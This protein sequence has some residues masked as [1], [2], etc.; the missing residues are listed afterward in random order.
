MTK[1]SWDPTAYAAYSS[2]TVGKSTAHIYTKSG[3][4]PKLDP[5]G[6]KIRES[7]D[8]ATYPASTALIVGLDV[9]GS[10]GMI[11]DTL[12]RQGLGVL[13]QE[14]L[15]RKPITDPQIMFMA[16]GDADYDRGPLQVSQ[17]EVDNCIIEQLTSIWLE[18]G[19]GGN[20]HESYNMPWYFAA[21][22][23]SIDCFE[24]RKKKGYLFTVGDEPCPDILT[25]QHVE[26]FLGEHMERDLETDELLALVG[27]TYNVFHVIVQEGDYARHSPSRVQE[28]WAKRLGQRVL[29]L[30]D[31]TK[32][33][34]VI[35]S[36]I[37]I[38]EGRD[39]DEVISS[40]K[41]GTDL[42]VR[43]AVTALTKGGKAGVVRL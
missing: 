24:K 43:D 21:M 26:E 2:S 40:W 41:G 20:N 1:H 5:K 16:I 35:V 31:H 29:P 36:A 12:A 9:T 8:S 22:H 4:D 13:F 11:A 3:M 18:H 19:G 14:I 30:K 42:V 6:V 23:T 10:M 34:E 33:S 15:D 17:F 39:K 27:K 28:S 38:T 32:L 25:R 7:R 37:E